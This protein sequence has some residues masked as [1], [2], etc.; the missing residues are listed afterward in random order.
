MKTF[1]MTALTAYDCAGQ[2]RRLE[3][4]ARHFDQ[5]FA[6]FVFHNVAYMD[7]VNQR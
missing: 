6:R 3:N 2:R 7:S 1:R 5:I 4:K